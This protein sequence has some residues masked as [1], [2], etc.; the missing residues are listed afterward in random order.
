[1]QPHK[2]KAALIDK[3]GT[4]TAAAEALNVPLKKLSH[5]I[6]HHRPYFA[7]R[8][9]IAFALGKPVS[10]LFPPSKSEIR[11]AA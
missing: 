5:C 11:A 8:K 3:Y 2:I 4:L 10:D 6:T 7:I 9:Q 1:M